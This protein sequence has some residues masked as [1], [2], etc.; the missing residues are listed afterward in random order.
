MD[1][2]PGS[3]TDQNRE[4]IRQKIV[5]KKLRSIENQGIDMEKELVSADSPI[6]FSMKQLWFELDD[7]ER[8]T[9]KESRKSDTVMDKTKIGN[10]ENLISNEYPPASPGGGFPFLNN[11]AKGILG[12]LDS[13]RIKL[14]D[15]T[16][17]FLFEPG[18]FLPNNDGVVEK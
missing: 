5:E 17:K 7:F 14:N 1:I 3:I 13:I 11:G 16:Y 6:P 2:F 4:Y 10:A 15:S 9:F 18:E 12:F 8:Q